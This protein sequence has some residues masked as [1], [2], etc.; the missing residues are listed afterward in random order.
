MLIKAWKNQ[1]KLWAFAQNL[2]HWVVLLSIPP[3]RSLL[4]SQMFPWTLGH[5]PLQTV[6][7]GG[8]KETAK[9][10][11]N[12]GESHRVVKVAQS[13]ERTVVCVQMY[14]NTECP[15]TALFWTTLA[16]HNQRPTP[17]GSRTSGVENSRDT[18]AGWNLDEYGTP[19][20]PLV[21]RILYPLTLSGLWPEINWQRC[22]STTIFCRVSQLW[23]QIV[24]DGYTAQ[25]WA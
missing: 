12:L 2:A 8:Q 21:L 4:S 24:T 9:D 14:Y 6:S 17:D 22:G 7:P 5:A 13:C 18:W 20:L 10:R 3:Q 11:S 19:K 16:S 1:N 15:L 25:Y 23:P